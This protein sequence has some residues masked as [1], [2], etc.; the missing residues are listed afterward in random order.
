MSAVRIKGRQRK[1]A[2]AVCLALV[3]FAAIVPIATATVV[4]AI[5]TPL[6][7]VVPAVVVTLIRRRASR[8]DEQPASLLSLVLSRAPPVCIVVP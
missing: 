8:C 7:L 2:A 4:Y 1:V 5:L 3:V 6:W